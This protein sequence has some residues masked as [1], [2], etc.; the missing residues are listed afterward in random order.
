MTGIHKP[1][2]GEILLDG[3]STLITNPLDAQAHGIAAIHQEPMIFPDLN[4]AEN[5]F[6]GH[7]N[8]AD[9]VG[10]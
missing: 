8:R 4:V 5:I 7:R 3:R 6:I 2:D 9:P 10:V 1:D